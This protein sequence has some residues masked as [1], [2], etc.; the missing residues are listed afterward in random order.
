MARAT[1]QHHALPSHQHPARCT[2]HANSGGAKPRQWPAQ[3]VSTDGRQALGLPRFSGQVGRRAG[4]T[5]PERLSQGRRPQ[6]PQPP[7]PRPESRVGIR[8]HE[9]R[10]SLDPDPQDTGRS[11]WMFQQALSSGRTVDNSNRAN[12]RTTKDHRAGV[13]RVTGHGPAR[14]SR[15]IGRPTAQAHPWGA[16]HEGGNADLLSIERLPKGEICG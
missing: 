13:A 16:E 1:P 14:G 2:A 4:A 15:H 9:A 10:R 6:T 7:H 3:A 12:Q 8:N 11:E 5:T